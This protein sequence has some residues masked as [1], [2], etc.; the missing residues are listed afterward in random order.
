V[1]ISDNLEKLGI[2]L[3]QTPVP[4]AAYVPAVQTG[5]L[6]F[7]SGQ[8]PLVEGKLK[9]TGLVGR[10]VSLEQAYDAARLCALNALAALKSVAGD[11]ER[12]ARV[13]KLTGWVASVEQFTDQAKVMNGASELIGQIFGERGKHARAAVASPV[14]PL[15]ASVEVELIVE[16]KG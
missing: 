3:P 13:V 6:V 10:D 2:V 12:V 9:Y 7:V 15:N 5:N 11:L 8:L 1:S 16:L 14:L 4:V